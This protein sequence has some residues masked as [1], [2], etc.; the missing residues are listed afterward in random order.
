M[1]LL[2]NRL[3]ELAID[4][5]NQ[6]SFLQYEPGSVDQRLIKE[7]AEK[8]HKIVHKRYQDKP[9]D[10]IEIKVIPE[11]GQIKVV[12]FKHQ[13]VKAEIVK[14][15]ED[16]KTYRLPSNWEDILEL[17]ISDQQCFLKDVKQESEEWIK[18]ETYFKLTMTSAT[19]LQVQRV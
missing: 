8:M 15:I 16:S 1:A 6:Y 12:G 2:R 19:I 11:E 13:Q 4:A 10:L 17:L 5:K 7:I 3:Y 14:V 18:I 9:G